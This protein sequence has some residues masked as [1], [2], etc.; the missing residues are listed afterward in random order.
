MATYDIGDTIRLASEFAQSSGTATDPT[1]VT[2]RVKSPAGTTAVYTYSSPVTSIDRTAAGAYYY[3]LT[4]TEAG[5]WTYR[6]EGTG[7][8]ATAE[9]SRLFV[10]KSR[11]V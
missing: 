4:I 3:D 6:W 8:V 1:T 11:I 9:E 2:L 5:T 10:R 7:T